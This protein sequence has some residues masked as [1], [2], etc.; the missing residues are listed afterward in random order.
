MAFAFVRNL[1][2]DGG[3]NLK[4][5]AQIG[6]AERHAKR[7][8]LAGPRRQREKDGHHRNLF[9]SC[10]G[11]G[12]A[13]G[14]ADYARAF[15]Y[16]KSLHGVKSE[17]K[18]AALGLHLLVGVS[19]EW[20]AGTG[21][22]RDTA[23]PR[24][25]QLVA[26]AK[27]WAES[28]MGPGA[29]W[30]VRYDTDEF[31]A[32]VVDVLA[33]PVRMN[34]AGTGKQKPQ[35]SVNKALQ[36][37]HASHPGEKTSYAAMQTSW[38]EYAQARLDPALQRGNPDANRPHL[39]PDA[40]KA[41]AEQARRDAERVA[42]ALLDE[43]RGEAAK[44]VEEAQRAALELLPEERRELVAL[45]TENKQLLWAYDRLNGA[46]ELTK[47]ILQELLPDALWQRVRETYAA[48]WAK[49][50]AN[51]PDPTLAVPQAHQ[52][53]WTGPSGP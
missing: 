31:G 24:V 8:D 1:R 20:L 47:A 46:F 13:D 43:A 45:R 42:E 26:E 34:G 12:L 36:E 5:Y 10:L 18:G 11:D 30:A 37:L 19:P 35:I 28:W 15:K 7:Q 32:G 48:R 9:W 49:D 29:V 16:H 3:A 17:R 22:P 44:I 6:S 21:D 4:T 25:Q 41:A 51:V 52:K 27:A 2:T 23:N 39:P 33:S 53:G 50:P 40:F 38:A 14:G